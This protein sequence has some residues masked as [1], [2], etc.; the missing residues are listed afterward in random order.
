MNPTE[1]QFVMAN[2]AKFV[3]IWGNKGD[4]AFH[5]TCKGGQAN[6]QL[7]VDLGGPGDFHLPTQDMSHFPEKKKSP[8][9]RRRE[10]KRKAEYCIRRTINL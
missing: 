6:L 9:Q 5:L 1:F 8:S 2:M 7:T 4:R 3:K 10:A